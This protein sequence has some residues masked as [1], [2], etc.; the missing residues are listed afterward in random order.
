[1]RYQESH[2]EERVM[3]RTLNF[4]PLHQLILKDLENAVTEINVDCI[5]TLE[6]SGPK[7]IW[8]LESLAT[9]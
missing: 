5:F 4:G 6:I 9:T 3:W 1:L 2:D 7:M 8:Q